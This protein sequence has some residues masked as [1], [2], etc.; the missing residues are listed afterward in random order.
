MSQQCAIDLI[1]KQKWLDPVSETMLQAVL[2]AFK[3]GGEFGRKFK[4]FLPG[5]WLEHPLHPILTR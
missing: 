1:N 3:T 4:N 2:K 5:T